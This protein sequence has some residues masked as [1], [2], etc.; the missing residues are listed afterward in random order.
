[1]LEGTIV[2]LRAPGM[3]DL[4][5][6]TRWINDREVTRY[7]SMRYEISRLAEEAWLRDLVSK[8]MTFDR[9]FFAIET[10][11]GQHIG[12]TNLFK[13]HPEEQ[14][15]EL[16]IMIGEKSH[17]SKGYGTDALRTLLRFAFD[18]MN[19]NRVELTVYDFNERG[20]AAYRKAGF[21]EEGRRREAIY[22]EGAY[23]DLIVMSVLHHEWQR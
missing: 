14:K 13:T 11:D 19:M 3:D 16:G 8:P 5:R 10:K 1:M 6:N 18:E 17:W 7:L 20:Q 21:A 15:C 4:D 23:H 9:A 2:N 22:T 12:N